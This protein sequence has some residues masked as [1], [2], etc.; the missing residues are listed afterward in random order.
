MIPKYDLTA[1]Q[2]KGEGRSSTSP[3]QTS[4][5]KPE[6]GRKTGV[7][8]TG[9]Q[10]LGHGPNRKRGGWN[11]KRLEGLGHFVRDIALEE[12]PK[13]ILNGPYDGTPTFWPPAA[14]GEREEEGLR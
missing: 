11:E 3:R 1:L 13:P 7:R 6:D 10:K 8:K 2:L 12:P 14:F 4:S 9:G 5:K